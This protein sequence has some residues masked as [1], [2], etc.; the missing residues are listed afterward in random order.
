MKQ[1]ERLNELYENAV[2]EYEKTNKAQYG[3]L[4]EIE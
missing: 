1:R 4:L 2:T 3:R